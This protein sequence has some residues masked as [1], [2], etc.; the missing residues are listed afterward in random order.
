MNF[1]Y[2]IIIT[3]IEMLLESVY[4]FLI[5]VVRHNHAFSILGISALI[6][7]LCLPLYSK[8]ER[9]QEKE[10]QIRQKMSRRVASIKKHF[11]GDE[12]HMIL[13]MYYRENHYH[14]VMALRSSISLVIQIPFFIAAY[15]FLSHYTALKGESFLVIQDLGAPDG[16]LRLGENRI[17][18]LPVLMTAINIGSASIY[19]RGFAIKEKMQLYAMA[20]LFLVLLYASP[21][22]LVLYW[23]SNNVFSLLKNIVYKCKRPLRVLYLTVVLAL[24]SGCLYVIFFRSQSRTMRFYFSS[25][26]I[27]LSLL[28]A[29][30]PLYVRFINAFGRKWFRHL[31]NSFKELHTLYALA[32]IGLFLLSGFFIPFN[33]VASDPAEF[34][35]VSAMASPFSALVPPLFI[36]LGLFV[37]WPLLIYAFAPK[38]VKAL[39]AF[40][41]SA[42]LLVALFNTFL[43]SGNYGMLSQTLTFPPGTGFSPDPSLRLL[44]ALC[45]VATGVLLLFVFRKSCV[46]IIGG[47]LTIACF[48]LVILGFGKIIEIKRG[49][50]A[51]QAVLAANEDSRE[52]SLP[53]GALDRVIHLSKT[54]KNVFLIMLDRAIGSYFPLILE[55]RRELEEAF[56]GF[57]YYPNTVSF[58]RA[59][60]L[61]APPIFGGYEYTPEN[62]QKRRNDLM[63]DKHNESLLMLPELFREQGYAASFFDAPYV[64]Y[65]SVMEK[66]FFTERGIA[67]DTLDGK[68]AEHFIGELGPDAPV[69]PIDMDVVLRRNFVM[70]SLFCMAPPD[71]RSVIYKNGSY[72]SV[73]DTSRTDVV[74]GSSLGSYAEL[75]YLPQISDFDSEKNTFT[76]LVNYL[77]HS[78]SLLQYPDY[79]VV[80]RITDFGPER[81]NG[82]VN[83]LQHYH[84]NIAAYLLLARWFDWMRDNGV[85]DNTRIIIVSDHDEM[86]IK[87]LFSDALNNINT[88][89]NPVLLVKDFDS[90]GSLRTDSSFMTTADVPILAVKDIAPNPKNPFTGNELK[91]EKEDGVNIFLGGSSMLRD[92]AGFAS[93]D[94]VSS[95]Y[96]VH[97][98]IFK[99][100]NWTKF[101]RKY[102]E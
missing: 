94:R 93:L 38:K 73:I 30:I 68:Y 102:D 25:L 59:T 76:A 53:A 66:S 19:T 62:L 61:G 28:V 20:I 3:P 40:W 97:D 99:E 100:K 11:S 33:V 63:L 45:L 71:L 5:V 75:Y 91:S 42:I 1:L 57:V 31:V 60:N 37:L 56:S 70:Y 14:P 41:F 96:H 32:C 47:V 54:E 4:S 22:A 8:A 46:K 17:N 16:L 72:W 89:Y 13:S 51:Y 67:T 87:P 18:L 6:T 84:V 52:D 12:R 34:A 64:N 82:H 81:F 98:D 77:T 15:H 65:Q 90:G 78:P 92:Y 101:T 10:R 83:S 69:S 58:F 85:Y 48:S 80:S 86:V 43:F 27:L 9:I 36:A 55:E 74:S 26:S 21:S 2:L 95:F 39:L 7:L 88:Y 79:T 44:N 29:A 49:Y 50:A 35:S 24:F 23:T